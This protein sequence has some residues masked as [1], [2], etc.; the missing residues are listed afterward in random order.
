MDSNTRIAPH[1]LNRTLSGMDVYA[2][3]AISLQAKTDP[4]I[5]NLSFGEPEFGP[6]EHLLADISGND[7]SLASFLNAAKRYEEPRGNLPLR[8]AIAEW[9]RQRYNLSVD[10]EREVM[11]THGG[12]EAITLALLAITETGD[13]VAV[14]NPSYMLYL[15]AIKTLGRRPDQI[16][17]QSGSSEYAC[18]AQQSARLAGV[19]AMIINSPENPTGYVAGNEDWEYIAAAAQHSGAWIIH[20]EVYDVMSF[21]RPHR[22]ARGVPGLEDRSILVN[23]C[24]KKFGLP[25]LR[26]GWLVA[27]VHVIDVAA[28][29]H[30]YLY[31]G[32]NIQFEKIALRLLSDPR[33]DQWL[34][35]ISH[36]LQH[37]CMTARDHL[38]EVAGYRWP[39]QPLGA[40]F[41]FPEVS[42][43]YEKIPSAYRAAGVSVS[44][45]VARYLL[46][47]RKVA[48]VPGSVYGSEGN[49]H[50]RLV[51][52]TPDEEYQRALTRMR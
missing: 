33:K 39:R 24:S 18:L 51:L 16:A 43:L 30:D 45:A 7:L 50:I 41:L 40:M 22:P 25:G 28:K 52:C 37:R 15:R 3:K 2:S 6:P 48:V 46:E 17:R 4:D 42:Q 47:E 19:K 49:S 36:K 13:R 5:A 29:A 27:P 12:V 9:Y 26:I 1:Q 20:D 38:D 10:P 8:R 44:D 21:E 31:L 32:V 11:V 34:K 14:T 23:S 35:E